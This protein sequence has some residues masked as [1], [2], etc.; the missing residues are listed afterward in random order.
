MASSAQL[1]A[2]VSS[3]FVARMWVVMNEA[4]TGKNQFHYGMNQV[5]DGLGKWPLKEFAQLFADEVHV[6]F[7]QF[8]MEGQGD[9]SGSHR[10]ADR[11]ITGLMPELLDVEWL[12]VYGCEIVAAS[13]ASCRECFQ[14]AVTV[15]L[16]V[17]V[18]QPHD[19]NKPTHLYVRRNFL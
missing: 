14:D 9:G 7:G 10:F 11:K 15:V 2:H 17:A 18:G 1:S 12:E 4:Y 3:T 16:R 6:H 13:D 5:L 8:M 19:K